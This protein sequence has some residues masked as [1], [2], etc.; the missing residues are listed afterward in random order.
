MKSKDKIDDKFISELVQSVRVTI[1]VTVE[2][3]LDEVMVQKKKRWAPLLKRP[4]L[5][6][7]VSA[8]LAAILLVV[9]FVFTPFINSLKDTNPPI[10]EIK[11]EFEIPNK[12]IKIIWVQKKD[13]KLN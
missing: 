2:E 13:F 1:P 11:T 9:L 7:P 8:A 12:N 4:F 10:S 6:Y 3:S 5:W